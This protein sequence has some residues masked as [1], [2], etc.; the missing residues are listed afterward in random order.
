MMNAMFED[1][2]DEVDVMS[3]LFPPFVATRSVKPA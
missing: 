3:K 2:W 1:G